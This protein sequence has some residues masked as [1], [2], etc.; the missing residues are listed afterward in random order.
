MSHQLKLYSTQINEYMFTRDANKIHHQQQQAGFYVHVMFPIFHI[1]FFVTN[2]WLPEYN[3]SRSHPHKNIVIVQENIKARYWFK[4]NKVF[5]KFYS[6]IFYA[7]RQGIRAVLV[8]LSIVKCNVYIL[9]EV[10]N[11]FCGFFYLS[12]GNILFIGY[13]SLQVQYNISI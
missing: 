1:P 5:S 12:K 3:K 4:C 10:L 8:H 11:S 7:F 6:S 13:Y 9:T 2:I